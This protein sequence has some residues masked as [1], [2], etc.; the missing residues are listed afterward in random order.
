[1]FVNDDDITNTACR[2]SGYPDVELIGPTYPSFGTIYSLP[3]SAGRTASVAVRFGQSA[4][5]V[6]TWLPSDSGLKDRWVPGYVRVV[7]HTNRGPSFAMALP[8]RYGSVLRQDGA[9]HPGTYVGA[10]LR[11]KG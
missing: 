6:L 5:S 1:V 4:H 8:W 7:V 9:T 2:I 11:G 10:I 3:Q